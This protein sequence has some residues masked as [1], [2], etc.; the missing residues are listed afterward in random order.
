MKELTIEAG[1]GAS[2]ILIGESIR[3]L[4]QYTPEG[5][6]VIVTDE[7]VW[8]HHGQ[9]FSHLDVIRIGTG[10][11]IKTLETVEALYREL[12]ERD[13][14]RSG[15]LVGIGG[16]IVCDIVG[17]VASTYMRGVPFGFVS[18]TLLS[19]VDASVGGK[20]GVNLRGYKNMIGVFNQPKFVICDLDL[21]TTLPQR[22]L[23]CGYAEIVKHAAIADAD[24][25][26]FLEENAAGALE[27]DLDV[28]ERLVTD[29]VIIKSAIV[30]RDEKESGERR[31]LN[32]GHTFGHAIETTMGVPHGEAVSTGMAVA[33]G[34]SVER[35]GLSP[36][37]ADRILDL[38]RS[39]SLP[40]HRPDDLES[41]L[42]A[43]QKDKKRAGDTIHFVLLRRI[44]SAFVEEMPMGE[45]RAA[46]GRYA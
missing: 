18:S 40:V 32:F 43:M 16:G 15:F 12:L 13:M 9:A 11:R 7:N 3:N 1:S 6:T 38:L 23:L 39:L 14:D 44:G 28:I 22:E 4:Q 8:R 46:V 35:G 42:S 31:K 19:Q 25:F 10:E 27:L 45:M 33:A 41:V 37:D 5:R 2:S 34:L 17:F 36:A 26:A 20:N 30:S 29:S 21:L 24:M